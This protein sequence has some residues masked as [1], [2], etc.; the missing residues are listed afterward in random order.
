M[1]RFKK[2][3]RVRLARRS[4]RSLAAR[5]ADAA[6]LFTIL[7]FL[8]LSFARHVSRQGIDATTTYAKDKSEDRKDVKYRR[9]GG[10]G[11]KG[12]GGANTSNHL[13]YDCESHCCNEQ[14]ERSERRAANKG[15]R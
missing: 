14:T 5:K 9:L 8:F 1:K 12:K 10:S 2:R 3:F 4:P 11:L 13:G 7:T 6:Y 15:S